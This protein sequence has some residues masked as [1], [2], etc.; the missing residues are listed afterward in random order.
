[1]PRI[2]GWR[3]SG[4]AAMA[5][6]TCW[7]PLMISAVVSGYK[8]GDVLLSPL[9]SLSLSPLL[10]FSL[11]LRLSLEAFSSSSFLSSFLLLSISSLLLLP[12]PPLLPLRT[13]LKRDPNRKIR[14]RPV[15]LPR[16]LILLGLLPVPPSPLLKLSVT[17]V[18]LK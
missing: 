17:L 8:T 11:S 18:R 16:P 3:V 4:G 1:M 13:P 14:N 9:L 7:G 10:S 6:L 5:H 2:Q 15:S 12:L